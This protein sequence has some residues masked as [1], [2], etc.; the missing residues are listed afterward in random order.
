[1]KKIILLLII[2]IILVGLIFSIFIFDWFRDGKVAV[3]FEDC[4]K[5]GFPVMES[6]PRQCRD[7]ANRTFTEEIGNIL[8]KTNLINVSSPT[9]NS[10]N[11]SPLKIAGQARGLW[12]F[13]ASFPVKI[14]DLD[15]KTL[16]SGAATTKDEWMTD[17]FVNF[18]ANL[19]FRVSTT[20]KAILVL[21]KDNPSGLEENAN[22][23][24]FPITLI[25]GISVVD[26]KKLEDKS[27]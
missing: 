16:A 23:L 26:S 17:S 27:I 7:G 1:M 5:S 21:D 15:G 12:F 6:Y 19:S 25:P 4:L 9:P 18:E 14:Q 10:E 8:I 3:D 20:T 22:S 11:Y 13:E 2:G 24:Y